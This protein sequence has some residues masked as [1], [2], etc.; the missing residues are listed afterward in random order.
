LAYNKAYYQKN[1]NQVISRSSVYY[2]KNKIKITDQR[3]IQHKEIRKKLFQLLG[4][5][6]VRCGFSDIRALQLDR[7]N[8]HGYDDRKKFKLSGTLLYQFYLKNPGLA[9]EKL[10][11]LCANCN[12][13]KRDENNENASVN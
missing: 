8:G 6:C 10:Q 1:K 4:N 13:I 11:I 7:K 5:D 3:R 9:K 12:W 2:Y